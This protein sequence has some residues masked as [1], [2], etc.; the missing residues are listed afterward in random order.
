MQ[1]KRPSG[2]MNNEQLTID[3]KRLTIGSLQ[4]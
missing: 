1:A 4:N 2:T 3:K